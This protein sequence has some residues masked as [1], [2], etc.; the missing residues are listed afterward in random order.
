MRRRAPDASPARPEGALPRRPRGP[1]PAPRAPALPLARSRRSPARGPG[2]AAVLTVRCGRGRWS[3]RP[4]RGEVRRRP[5]HCPLPGSAQAAPRLLRSSARQLREVRAGRSPASP[6]A[7]TGPFPQVGSRAPGQKRADEPLPHQEEPQPRG[8]RGPLRS[9]GSAPPL[10]PP[11]TVTS[12]PRSAL[13]TPLLARLKWKTFLKP[14]SQISAV[15]AV[16]LSWCARGG[17]VA[18][19]RRF[20]EAGELPGGPARGREV[21]R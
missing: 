7:E 21:P 9:S 1:G 3:C 6:A 2:R 15:P 4:G 20:P 17:G 16:T 13:N 12:L 18:L 8:G 14:P 19:D 5:G 11:P 10:S